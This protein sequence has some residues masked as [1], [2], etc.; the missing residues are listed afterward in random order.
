MKPQRIT[1]LAQLV[2]GVVF[3][4][5]EAY[6]N[7]QLFEINTP[8]VVVEGPS[9]VH[10]PT[11]TERPGEVGR[12]K[13][14]P[15]SSKWYAV[16]H[17]QGENPREKFAVSV[18]TEDGVNIERES[19]DHSQFFFYAPEAEEKLREVHALKSYSPDAPFLVLATM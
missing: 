12:S 3:I 4:P 1:E 14:A 10:L 5:V 7:G 6:G 2:P 15:L 11:R 16:V 18:H 13:W 17:R 9:N 8:L 19:S